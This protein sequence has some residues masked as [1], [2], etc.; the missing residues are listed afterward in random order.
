MGILDAPGASPKLLR[1]TRAR[2]LA[3]V[4]D[5]AS[6]PFATGLSNGTV[7]SGTARLR[8]TVLQTSHGIVLAFS[9]TINSAGFESNGPQPITV[10]AC[11]E[12]AV[13]QKTPAYFNG[14]R[15]I[16]IAPGGTA[17][18]D[19][20]GVVLAKGVVFYTSTYISVA[21]AAT[22]FPQAGY[23]TLASDTEGNNYGAPGA[24]LTN[25][26]DA[27]PTGGADARVYGPTAILG[28]PVNPAS[29]L[30]IVGDSIAA[31]GGDVASGQDKGWITRALG[32]NYAY[33]RVALT[34]QTIAGWYI[35]EGGA[36]WRQ[37]GILERVG[38][39]HILCE[40]GINSISTGFASMASQALGDGKRGPW[41][42]LSN[43]GVPVWVTT[44]TPSTTSTDA[45]ATVANQ[46]VTA[47]E[48]A[49]VSYNNW[50]RDGAPIT[51]APSSGGVAAAVGSTGTI[52]M[53]QP[54]HPLAGYIEVADLAES[55]RDSGK[56]K[57]GYTVDGLH[58][59]QTA[60]AALAAALV[61]ANLGLV[62]TT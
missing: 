10:S 62:A 29:V 31:G 19:P 30:G 23:I 36:K 41:S 8:H 14:Q 50:I 39:T 43:F 58:P 9:N 52:R 46:T 22:K 17:Y 4:A 61:P 45:W 47:N 57:A 1:L 6:L 60:H 20:I 18:T 44:L 54:G 7:T 2:Q 40:L 35:Q 15:Q 12:H 21:S 33:Q 55:A 28:Q 49:R 5:R 11:I 13:S 59:N 53:G 42:A 56:W 25:T 34:G 26:G 16:T 51:A 27:N 3:P 32:N 38:P 24:E 48:A 37:Q